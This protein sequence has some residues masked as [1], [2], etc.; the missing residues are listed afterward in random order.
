MIEG[1]VNRTCVPCEDQTDTKQQVDILTLKT[2]TRTVNNETLANKFFTFIMFGF[3]VICWA[4][5]FIFK[6]RFPLGVSIATVLTRT[7]F[8]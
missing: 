5:L 4:L 6:L 8:T 1:M 7:L 2:R 3:K